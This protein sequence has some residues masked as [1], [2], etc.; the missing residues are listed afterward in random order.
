MTNIKLKLIGVATTAAFLA[1][2]ITEA[3]AFRHRI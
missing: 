3:A 1:L 2:P